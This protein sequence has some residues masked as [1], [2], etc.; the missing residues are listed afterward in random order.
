MMGRLL[1]VTCG[2]LSATFLGLWV[3]SAAALN[4]ME[5]WTPEATMAF[6]GGLSAAVLGVFFAA[7]AWT[8]W[9]DA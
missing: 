7:I 1:A 2:A 8:A 9:R 6:V 4:A 3:Y 5:S